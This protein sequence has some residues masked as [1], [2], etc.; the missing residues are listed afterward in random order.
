MSDQPL[1]TRMVRIRALAAD[2]RNRFVLTPDAAERAAIAADLD[3]LGLRKL[4]F[5]VALIPQAQADWR[6]E[7]KLGATVVQSCV[8]SLAP[9]TTR[10]DVAVLRVYLADPPPLPDAD[11]IEMPE[12]DSTEPLPVTLDLA[13][14][15]TEALALALPEYPHAEG[16]AP[17][18]Q[19]YAQPGPATLSDAEAR[20]F[21]GLAG[22][23]DKLGQKDR[24]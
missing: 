13:A 3:I 7:A 11:E 14:V 22:L 20:P 4:R 5:E 15:M 21:A 2:A 1:T 18:E 23:R 9:V 10:I 6:L 16:V 19:T 12:D 24:E 8:V 17:L